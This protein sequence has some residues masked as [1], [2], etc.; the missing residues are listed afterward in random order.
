MSNLP[1]SVYALAALAVLLGGFGVS[2]SLFEQIAPYLGSYESYVSSRRREVEV[3]N[4]FNS[5]EVA[6]EIV[7]RAG[8]Q[9]GERAWTRRFINLPLGVANLLLSAMLFAGALRALQR[10][11]W[12]HGAWQFAARLSI[13]YTA[14]HAAV[15]MFTARDG[16]DASAALFINLSLQLNVPVE[17][18]ADIEL[19]RER[20]FSGLW[21]MIAIGFFVTCATFL[22]RPKVKALFSE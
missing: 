13:P 15:A 1:R 18:L 8:D 11:A 4:G 19:M 9:L 3:R 5:P 7:Q 20:V 22:A 10:S 12:G 2:R 17:T 16:W 21:A 14:L 6:S